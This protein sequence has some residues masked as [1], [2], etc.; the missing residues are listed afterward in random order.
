MQILFPFLQKSPADEAEYVTKIC[1]ELS[2]T[3]RIAEDNQHIAAQKK[4][5]KK[6]A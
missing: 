3:F 4:F 1:Q 6:F 2:Q 5:G